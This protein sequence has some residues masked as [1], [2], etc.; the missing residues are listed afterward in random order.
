MC[1]SLVILL[2]LGV[3]LTN[4][5]SPINEFSA[6]KLPSPEIRQQ[7]LTYRL[8][9]NVRPL[10]YELNIRINVED[11]VFSGDVS[12]NLEVTAPT[13]SIHLNYKDVAVDWINARLA[14]DATGQ[15][16]QVVNE[17]DRSVEQ[18]YELHFQQSL[19]VGSYTLQLQ[20]DGNIRHDLTGLYKS[21]YTFTNDSLSETR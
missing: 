19:E 5:I 10:K 13:T 4:S 18:I 6:N 16:F 14:L 7:Q 12:I 21:S 3:T 9:T 17:V 15:T 1:K 2:A 20:F 11:E 8:P